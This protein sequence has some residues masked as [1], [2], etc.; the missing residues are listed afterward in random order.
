MERLR[1][2]VVR[3]KDGEW[4]CRARVV[5]VWSNGRSIVL[6]PGVTYRKGTRSEWDDVAAMLDDW[7]AT[8]RLPLGVSIRFL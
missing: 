2:A 5:F 7:L 1:D 3:V 8:D 6:A 4:F